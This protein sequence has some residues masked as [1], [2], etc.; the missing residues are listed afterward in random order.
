MPSTFSRTLR[1]LAADGFGRS[2]WALV[3]IV[4]LLGAGCIWF[5]FAKVSVYETTD[6]A[7]LEVERAAHPVAAPVAGKV[8]ASHLVLGE[9]VQVGDLLVEL[10]SE[11]ERLQLEEEQARLAANRRRRDA[12]R[13]QLAAEALAWPEEKRTAALAV[14]EARARL[15]EV[16]AA[17]K[18]AEGE[19]E[20]SELL[21]KQG[22]SS[23]AELQRAQTSAQQQR[24]VASAQALTVT[25]LETEANSKEK[26]R[27]VRLSELQRDAALLDGDISTSEATLKRNEFALE[28]RRIRAPVSG[29]LGEI[30]ELKAGSF[31]GEGQKLGAIIPAGDLKLVAQFSPLTAAGRVRPGQPA[32]LRLAAFPWAQYGSIGATVISVANEPLDGQLRVELRVRPQ[33]VPLVPLQHGLLGSVEVQVERVSPA[34]LALR[35]AGKLL[36]LPHSTADVAAKEP[37]Q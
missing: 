32:R 17:A 27:A 36:A 26:T 16:E 25:R 34:R 20:R 22:V 4:A 9:S 37:L 14:E 31:L 11:R 8:T 23:A 19:A 18:F 28:Q 15:K 35:A 29:E 13:E 12:L 21:N 5:L 24:A 10:D 1:S 30:A 6:R 2:L 3:M 33:S 7:R